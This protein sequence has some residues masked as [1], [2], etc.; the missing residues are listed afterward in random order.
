MDVH[1]VTVATGL[2]FPAVGVDFVVRLASRSE[3]YR[4][5]LTVGTVQFEP[6]GHAAS[7]HRSRRFRDADRAVGRDDDVVAVVGELDPDGGAVRPIGRGL[8][9]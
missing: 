7:H 5:K 8:D 9:E 4:S 3:N 1:E 2:L 6:V